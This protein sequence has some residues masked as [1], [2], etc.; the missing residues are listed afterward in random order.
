[1]LGTL[2]DPEDGNDMILRNVG[3]LSTD[4][5]LFIATAVRTSNLQELQMFVIQYKQN[6]G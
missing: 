6:W 5:I 1:L 4:Y 2:F 3:R